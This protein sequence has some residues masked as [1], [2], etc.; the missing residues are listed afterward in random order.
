MPS[1]SDLRVKL[2][3]DGADLATMA[4]MAADPLIRGFTTNPTL[5]RKAGVSDYAAFARRA[6]AI[7][8]DRPL[9]FEVLSDDF[10]EMAAQAF[11]VA[12]WGANVFVKVPV[13]N[14][15]GESSARLIAHL[16]AMGVQVNV[17]AV[18][19]TAQVA[20]VARHLRPDVPSFVSIFAGR[21]ADTGR[22]PLPTIAESL[23]LLAPL[24]AAEVIWAS[25]RELLNVFQA[26]AVGCHVITATADVL[27]KLPLV[28]KDLTEFSLDTVRMFRR[29]AV[30]A[31]Y[32]IPLTAK[33]HPSLPNQGAL[34]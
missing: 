24:P 4:S 34:R 12:S 27:G 2:F 7:V 29:D 30:A 1:L 15:R 26:D 8:P 14:T 31:A 17:T 9:S 21:I 20:D 22:D 28:G 16:T 18:L 23:R 6:L 13:T 11:E 3:A 19:T 25:P 32:D 10:D 33:R 5:M